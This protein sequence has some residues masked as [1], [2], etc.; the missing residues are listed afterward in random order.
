[1]NATLIPSISAL[2][3]VCFHRTNISQLGET[4][5]DFFAPTCIFPGN[6]EGQE[7]EVP[8][9]CLDRL[10]MQAV[11]GRLLPRS[12]QWHAQVPSLRHQHVP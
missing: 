10:Q 9:Q 2:S 11:L 6:E 4:H 7:Q 8:M 12:R 1:M 3:F 5:F